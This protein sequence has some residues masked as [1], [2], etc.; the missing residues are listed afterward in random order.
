MV[1][2]SFEVASVDLKSAKSIAWAVNDEG[3]AGASAPNRLLITRN[4]VGAGAVI[5]TLIPHLIGQDERVH[6]SIPY[7]M[8][9]LTSKQ[10]TS[11]ATP[12]P[13]QLAS[14]TFQAS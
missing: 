11:S 10:V 9:G 6:R 13:T 3:D 4:Q 5:V 12:W 1:A 8:D 7:L 14:A 2:L